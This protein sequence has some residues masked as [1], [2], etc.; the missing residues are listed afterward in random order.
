MLD[1]V[2]CG[3]C[4]AELRDLVVAKFP[5]SEAFSADQQRLYVTKARGAYRVAIEN[6]Q[7]IKEMEVE[8][9]KNIAAPEGD[10]ECELDQTTRANVKDAWDAAHPWTPDKSM[11]AAPAFRNR[12]FREFHHRCMS[13][14]M[15]EKAL[16]VEDVKRPQ[17]RK[18]LS[19]AS[20][21]DADVYMEYQKQVKR[22]VDTPMAYVAAVR[23]ITG[24]YSFTGTHKVQSKVDP[25]KEVLFFPWG[26]SITATS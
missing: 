15:A 3:A 20:T 25:T 26:V 12:T 7:E 11:K 4:E 16:T 10:L 13:L 21:E 18:R 23:L 8:Q 22:T 19:W 24:T 9:K 5:L 2:V 6:E 1:M 14:H 17:E